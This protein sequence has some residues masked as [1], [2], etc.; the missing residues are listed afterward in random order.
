MVL[1]LSSNLKLFVLKRRLFTN[2]LLKKIGETW[3]ENCEECTC[4]ETGSK[5][6]TIDCPQNDIPQCAHGYE[7]VQKVTGCCP[8]Y[9]CVCDHSLC[10]NSTKPICGENYEMVA[11]NIN[12]ACCPEYRCVCAPERCP[13]TYCKDGERKVRMEEEFDCCPTYK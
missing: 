12:G 4:L 5:C 8:T 10:S 7:L 1:F 6:S 9:E 2:T 3:K 11:I 13:S